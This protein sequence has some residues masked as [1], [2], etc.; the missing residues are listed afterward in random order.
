MTQSIGEKIIAV[1]VE[2]K[3]CSTQ[4]FSWGGRNFY[5]S[6]S[7]TEQLEAVVE[8]H[9]EERVKAALE[10]YLEMIES[11]ARYSCHTSKADRDYNGQVAGSLVTDS[12][13]ISTNAH[14]LRFLSQLTPPRFRIIG[15]TGRMVVGYWPENDPSDGI[16]P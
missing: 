14:A 7:A 2:D 3:L 10:D 9:I 16:K 11:G 12:G 4:E 15:E 5:W 13:A 8:S 1:I 6:P